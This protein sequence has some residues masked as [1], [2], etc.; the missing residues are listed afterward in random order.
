MPRDA[1][2]TF[3]LV[4][5]NP[6]QAGALT[7]RAWANATLADI[8]DAL[9]DS[10]SRSGQGGLLGP[11]LVPSGSVTA[12]GVSFASDTGSGLYLPGTGD[13]RV[14][15]A[16]TQVARFYN[17]IL[18]ADKVN[19]GAAMAGYGE[20][21][22]VVFTNGW[23]TP[24]GGT[25]GYN[26]VRCRVPAQFTKTVEFT[27][28]PTINGWK[29]ANQSQ[30]MCKVPNILTTN[31]DQAV[32]SATPYDLFSINVPG[33]G[34]TNFEGWV[35]HQTSGTGVGLQMY[36]PATTG[37]TYNSSY[38]EY[39]QWTSASVVTVATSTAWSATT[40]GNS[41]A[42]P[43]TATR[44]SMVRGFVRNGGAGTLTAKIQAL[45]G[46]GA[47]TGSVTCYATSVLFAH[48]QN[49]DI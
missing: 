49:L 40:V 10:L 2:G 45:D 23:D 19:F 29:L 27:S 24:D 47:T 22:N 36:L 35:Y 31:A 5:G 4:A 17:G 46:S 28:A 1:N 15:A 14:A 8:E 39:H 42:G 43:G 20:Y 38:L 37:G 16:G 25:L 44:L 7:S 34:W 6:V 41:A 13:L 30:V 21:Q 48:S 32:N 9:T 11:F 12:P 18:S 33:Y 26:Q 3:T